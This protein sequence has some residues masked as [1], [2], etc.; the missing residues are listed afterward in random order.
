MN[1]IDLAINLLQLGT[2]IASVVARDKELTAEQEALFK[3][4]F[5]ALTKAP[6]W[7]IR[8]DQPEK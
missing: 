4:E 2:K 5:E 8:P 1:W 3:Q 6:H 7:Q